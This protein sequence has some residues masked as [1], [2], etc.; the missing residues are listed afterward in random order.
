MLGDLQPLAG[1]MGMRAVGEFLKMLLVHVRVPG[2]LVRVPGRGGLV[3]SQD[4]EP[5]ARRSLSG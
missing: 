4:G 3:E 1:F 2:G 5:S